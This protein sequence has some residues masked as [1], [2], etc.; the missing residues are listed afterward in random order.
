MIV[1]CI[2]CDQEIELAVSI[3]WY[4][5]FNFLLFMSIFIKQNSFKYSRPSWLTT[6]NAVVLP[7]KEPRILT[8]EKE[9]RRKK[10]FLKILSQQNLRKCWARTT[11][12]RQGEVVWGPGPAGRNRT[13]VAVSC[14]SLLKLG[15][16]SWLRR[17]KNRQVTNFLWHTLIF[18]LPLSHSCWFYSIIHAVITSLID[19]DG[20]LVAEPFA[21]VICGYA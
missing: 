16:K 4:L 7:V 21:D 17:V 20:S 5:K 10:F 13:S 11:V 18:F 19:V 9:Q 3:R 14:P 1:E 15:G 2:Y 8:G 12:T 6:R